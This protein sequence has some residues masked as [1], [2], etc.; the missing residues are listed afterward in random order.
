MNEQEKQHRISVLK[1]AI[2]TKRWV[3]NHP[4]YPSS[5]Q[6]KKLAQERL[7]EME[8]EL[9]VLLNSSKK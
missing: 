5:W 7:A 1:G 3:M 2:E 6:E 4:D 9:A 8:E